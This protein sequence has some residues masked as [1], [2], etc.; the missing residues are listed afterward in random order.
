MKVFKFFSIMILLL[1]FWGS[2]FGQDV[3]FEARVFGVSPQKI[4]LADID[5]TSQGGVPL[6]WLRMKNNSEEDVEVI[7]YIELFRES[8]N[9]GQQSLADGKTKPSLLAKGEEKVVT[10]KNID[11]Q[12]DLEG[13][14]INNTVTEIRDKIL[15]TGF[16]P[17]GRYIFSFLLEAKFLT[18]GTVVTHLPAEIILD[19]TN[20]TT[21]ELIY[22]G[23]PSDQQ[24]LPVV[25]TPQPT[26]VW[27]GNAGDYTII[28]AKKDDNDENQSPEDAIATGV[29]GQTLWKL[30]NISE[31]IATYPSNPPL[32]SGS[33]YYWQVLTTIGLSSNRFENFAS[34]IWGFEYKDPA[35]E[36]G[37]TQQI[38]E[39]NYLLSLL[40]SIPGLD[41]IL[42]DLTDQGYF[43]TSENMSYKDNQMNLA[44]LQL[45]INLIRTGDIELV[46]E[47]DNIKFEIIEN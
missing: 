21:I 19:I 18:S 29:E 33:I 24:D 37:S 3:E 40:N 5:L 22:P 47:N 9:E 35:S 11:T 23:R 6:F 20:T 27:S 10:D 17:D 46:K 45:I 34:E 8:G 26:F 16:L 39:E 7:L 13:F 43:P 1:S 25:S 42:S 31:T 2:S 15:A 41:Q 38:V 14:S 32:T 4:S 44:G 12:F 28:V 30:E 36:G